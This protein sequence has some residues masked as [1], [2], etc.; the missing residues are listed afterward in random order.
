[1]SGGGGGALFWKTAYLAN[2]II[3]WQP[4][5]QEQII[6]KGIQNSDNHEFNNS[7]D[8]TQ[9]SLPNHITCI[10]KSIT[11]EILKLSE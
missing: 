1:M 11:M 4:E 7:A 5:K 6:H 8:A 3:G 10:S 9:L 2:M